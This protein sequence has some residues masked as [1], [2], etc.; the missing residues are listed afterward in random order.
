MTVERLL[1][2][3]VCMDICNEGDGSRFTLTSLA[4]YLRPG[5]PDPLKARV[6]LNGQ[7]FY[8]L[9]GE[10]LET[11]RTG[12]SGSHRIVGMPFYDYLVN[13]PVIGSLFDR[14]MAG[15]VRYRHRPAVEAYNF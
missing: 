9:W 15:V 10:L 11:V 14:T 7:V 6:L 1:R 2:A 3:F 8:R 4:E 12:E 5:H 13:E